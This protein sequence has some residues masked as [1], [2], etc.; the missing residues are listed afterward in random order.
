MP[1]HVGGHAACH[2][3]RPTRCCFQVWGLAGRQA[4]Q[5]QCSDGRPQLGP[6]GMDGR[7]LRSRALPT[8]AMPTHRQHTAHGWQPAAGSGAGG[9]KGARRYPQQPALLCAHP[10]ADN[11]HPP[12]VAGLRYGFDPVSRPVDARL[13]KAQLL[14]GLSGGGAPT[15]G[16]LSGGNS[17]ATLSKAVPL[18]DYDGDIILVTNSYVAGGGDQ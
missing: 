1:A 8:G 2:L 9:A 18:A 13:V 6:L 7:R 3:S 10:T 5:R 17:T 14:V 12:Q 4:G 11:L 15:A 16:Y